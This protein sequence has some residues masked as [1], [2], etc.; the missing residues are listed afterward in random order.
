[1]NSKQSDYSKVILILL[2]TYNGK[3]FLPDFFDSLEK[4]SYP[5]WKLLIRDDGSSDETLEIIQIFAK[6]H[7]NR[8]EIIRD[9]I[10]LGAKGSFSKLLETALKDASWEY[11]MFAD[12]DD[13]WMNDKIT[14]T[15]SKMEQMKKKFTESAPL[16]VHTDLTV[17]D[18][19]LKLLDH[20]FWH[21]QFINPKEDSFNRL[22]MQNT[23]TGCTMMINRPLAQLCENIP[24]DAIMHDWWIAL[25]VS[26]FGHIDTVDRATILYRQH[27][28]NDTGAKKFNIK[29]ILKKVLR[30]WDTKALHRHLN[31][32]VK[33]AE[34]FLDQYRDQLNDETIEILEAFC[35][36]RDKNFFKKRH[37]LWKY[38]F[39][40]QGYIRNA[41]LFLRI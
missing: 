30:F 41:A 12:Q 35:H 20:S 19:L 9:N 13:V 38:K 39:Y 4:Q 21:Y 17:V 24:L 27:H 32:N 1:M 33:Q 40:K 15:R 25:I 16:L 5:D 34:K 2:S 6:K 14:V 8:I 26:I 36:F 28:Q 37:I 7:D 3:L 29:Y 23:V 18:S 31:K 22:L 10:N 11:L